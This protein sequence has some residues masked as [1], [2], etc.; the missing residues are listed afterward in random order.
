MLAPPL[1]LTRAR[2]EKTNP[3]CLTVASAGPKRQ[4]AGAHACNGEN[5]SGPVRSHL[6]SKVPRAQR[7]WPRHHRLPVMSC[8]FHPLA[9][10]ISVITL[11]DPCG[12]NT[13][14][15]GARRLW[16]NI[17]ALAC[18]LLVVVSPAVPDNDATSPRYPIVHQLVAGGAAESSGKIGVGDEILAVDSTPTLVICCRMC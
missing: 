17:S 2:T 3:F 18:P 1:P 5:C 16:C 8:F 10:E 6:P 15:H 13:H 4:H 9:P 14:T 11:L 7:S 12:F